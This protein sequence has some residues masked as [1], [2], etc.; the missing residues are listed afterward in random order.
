M[1]LFLLLP[2]VISSFEL[3]SNNGK[4]LNG[5]Y[6]YQVSTSTMCKTKKDI[7]F[8]LDIQEIDDLF[9]TTTKI[10]KKFSDQVNKMIEDF[11]TSNDFAIIG[12]RRYHLTK[13]PQTYSQ[14][15]LTCRDK[16]GRLVEAT[17]DN[18]DNIIALSKKITPIQTNIWQSINA[19]KNMLFTISAKGLPTKHNNVEITTTLDD[20]NDQSQCTI[21]ITDPLKFTTTSCTNTAITICETDVQPSD[22]LHLSILNS[23]LK[24]TLLDLKHH[25]YVFKQQVKLLPKSNVTTTTKYN[26][27][28]PNVLETSK[29]LAELSSSA[30]TENILTYS[31]F[32]SINIKKI[33]DLKTTLSQK[34]INVFSVVKECDHEVKPGD[35]KQENKVLIGIGTKG[36]TIL[37][38]ANEF[39]NCTKHPVIRVIPFMMEKGLEGNVIFLEDKCVE[40]PKTCLSNFCVEKEYKPSMC[41]KSVF[42]TTT[43]TCPELHNTTNFYFQHDKKIYFS[44]SMPLKLEGTCAPKDYVKRGILTTDTKCKISNVPFLN[45]TAIQANFSSF[46]KDGTPVKNLDKTEIPNPPTWIVVLIIVS[47]SITG[48]ISILLIFLYVCKKTQRQQTQRTTSEERVNGTGNITLT[49]ILK[50]PRP[51]HHNKEVYFSA[52]NTETDSSE[53]SEH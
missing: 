34:S 6:V 26:L 51:C 38:Q 53:D 29:G 43:N 46:G 30:L 31:Q 33:N 44:S 50:T 9:D 47:L 4:F 14:A 28:D 42:N 22:I 7:S 15:I 39:D 19:D 18:I 10:H 20:V 2:Q 13:T 25:I 41:C 36:S 5:H 27:I 23:N 35:T 8:A 45:N 49:S 21:F 12:K 24:S 17:N 40:T 11:K 16:K 48:L 3:V 1:F 37:Y 52:S 32:V